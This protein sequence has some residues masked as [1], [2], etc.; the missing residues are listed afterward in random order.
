MAG[1]GLLW[2]RRQ[3]MPWRYGDKKERF[4]PVREGEGAGKKERHKPEQTADP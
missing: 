4:Y 3:G 1:G 2:Y